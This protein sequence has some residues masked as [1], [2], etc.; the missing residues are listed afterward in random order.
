MP[1]MANAA[2][3]RYR[4]LDKPPLEESPLHESPRD[5]SPQETGDRTQPAAPGACAA[6]QSV[7]QDARVAPPSTTWSGVAEAYGPQ[8]LG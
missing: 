1:I 5:E 6:G 2:A 4:A 7:S 3:I 8:G